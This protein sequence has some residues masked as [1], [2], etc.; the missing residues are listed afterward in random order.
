MTKIVLNL[1]MQDSSSVLIRLLTSVLPVIDSFA[2]VD[3]GS[4]DNSK[5]IVKNFFDS[6][7]IPGE[8]LDY[9]FKSSK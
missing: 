6:A 9:P 2:I 3:T 1:V 8:I 5:E 7:G 4:V